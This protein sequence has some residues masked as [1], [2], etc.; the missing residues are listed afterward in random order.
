MVGAGTGEDILWPLPESEPEHFFNFVAV[1]LNVV[2]T[3]LTFNANGDIKVL[4]R[5]LD[6]TYGCQDCRMCR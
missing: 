2:R 1:Q 4:E 5:N 6:L 3:F